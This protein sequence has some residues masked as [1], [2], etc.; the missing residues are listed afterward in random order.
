MSDVEILIAQACH[1]VA[2]QDGL[3]AAKRWDRVKQGGSSDFSELAC[4]TA[5]RDVLGLSLP[6]HEDFAH[7]EQ[8]AIEGSMRVMHDEFCIV[9]DFPEVLKLDDRGLPHC[10][11]GP[12]HRWRDGWALY[13]WHGTRV[14]QAWIEDKAS[15]TAAFALT[16]RNTELRRAA[17]EIVGW[18]NVLRELN[19]WVVAEDPDP[20]R[21]RLVDVRLPG[22]VHRPAFFTSDAPPGGSSPSAFPADAGR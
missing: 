4:L 21:G 6:A 9:C 12:S 2:G 3:K 13:H 22:C 14:P 1:A 20:E 16:V 15:L 10:E 7:W 18:H 19:G 8:A 17:M 5:F 11:D